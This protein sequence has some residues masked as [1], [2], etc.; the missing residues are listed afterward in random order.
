MIKNWH[1]VKRNKSLTDIHLKTTAKG[2]AWN[3]ENQLKNFGFALPF[4]QPIYMVY[5]K[6]IRIPGLMGK[7]L[8]S[9]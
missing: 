5:T 4:P 3:F 7:S 6:F 8:E 1:E 9:G 2:F